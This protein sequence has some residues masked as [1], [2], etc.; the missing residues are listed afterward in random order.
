MASEGSELSLS[1]YIKNNTKA[2]DSAVKLAK[3]IGQARGANQLKP[4]GKIK[5]ED[6][7]E[8]G[9]DDLNLYVSNI[10]RN[11]REI[12]RMIA[13][14]ESDKKAAKAAARAEREPNT[15]PP[16][17]FTSDLVNFFRSVDMGAGLGGVKRLQDQPEMALFFNNGVGNLTFGVS[18][19]N[20]YGNHQKLSS[21]NTKVFLDASGKSALS[22]ALDAMKAAKRTQ[23]AS[24]TD[25]K[26]R[27]ALT[28]DLERLETGEIQNKD[29]MSIL[30][31]YSVKKT[32]TDLS[33]FAD[34]VAEMRRITGSLN[35][36]YRSQI[37]AARPP[38]P[39]KAPKEAPAAAA[40]VAPPV[41]KNLTMPSLPTATTAPPAVPVV[42]PVKAVAVPAI[43][44]IPSRRK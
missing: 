20:V 23:L 6:G 28:K 18:I 34:Q 21:G 31:F 26:K 2:F 22:G 12:P 39:T 24:T 5:L 13:K 3:V 29:Y 11:L 42:A 33:H 4:G 15:Q 17:Q 19:F 1:E 27:E 41:M 9:M 37:A 32:G 40:P 10:K 38:K 35:D 8:V 25:E 44:A 36:S 14:A 16:N 43:P 7:R 30:S